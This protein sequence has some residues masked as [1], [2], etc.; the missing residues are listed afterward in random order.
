MELGEIELIAL[1]VMRYD[2]LGTTRSGVD[3]GAIKNAS[4]PE[5]GLTM[6]KTISLNLWCSNAK[7]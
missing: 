7:L 6:S 1:Q 3:A 5:F 4:H 2:D